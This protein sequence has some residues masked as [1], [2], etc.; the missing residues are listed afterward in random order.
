VGVPGIGKSRLVFELFEEVDRRPEL[1]TWRQGR[2]L[3]YGEGISYWALGEMVKAQAGILEGDDQ[4]AVARKVRS[5]VEEVVPP[6]DVAWVEGWL[7]PLVGLE[8]ELDIPRDRREES[9]TAWRRFLEGLAER[10]SLV[11]VFEDIHWADDGLLDFI[12][13]LVDWSADA[14]MLVLCTTRPELLDRRA[15]WGGGK[16][17]ALTLALSPLSD[18]EA[19]RL[20]D[21]V[22]ADAPVPAATRAALVERASGNPL[23]AQQFARLVFESG[24]V[25]DARLPETVHGL[26]AARLDALS[27]DEKALLQDAAVIGKVFWTGALGTSA[28]PAILQ[29]LQ[30]KEFIRRE[31]RA[32]VATDAEYAFCHVLVRDVAYSQIPRAERAAK[33][34]RAAQWIESLGRPQDHAELLAHHYAAA[35]ELAG[36]DEKAQLAERTRTAWR[37]AG[38]RSFALY[39]DPAAVQA[40]T[41][42][43]ELTPPDDPEHAQLRFRLARAEVRTAGAAAIEG[44]RSAAEALVAQGD[45]ATAAEAEALLVRQVWLTGDREAWMAHLDRATELAAQAPPSRSKAVVL[46]IRARYRFLGGDREGALIAGQEALELA[47]ELGIDEIR[48][49]ALNSLAIARHSMGESG[50]LDDLRESIRISEA[51]GYPVDASVGWNN[52]STLLEIDGQMPEAQQAIREASRVIRRSGSPS[53]VRWSE[54]TL[55]HLAFEEGDWDEALRRLDEHIAEIEAGAGHYHEGTLRFTRAEIRI[56]RDL[57][58][59][60]VGDMDRGL[61]ASRRAGDPQSVIPALAITTF[62]R[63]ARGELAEANAALD[64]LLATRRALRASFPFRG[65][66]RVVDATIALGRGEEFLSVAGAGRRTPWLDAAER[67]VAGDWA[68]A[69]EGYA[70]MGARLDEALARLRAAQQLAAGSRADEARHMVE[71][72]IA[73]YRRAGATRYLREADEVLAG[74]G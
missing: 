49:H 29:N 14:P 68:G 66:A 22:L 36:P 42:A 58:D 26:I 46:A 50:A 2:S 54:L 23:D 8:S 34:R 18:D 43:L 24:G 35:M 33:H 70:Q 51:A 53:D 40:Y 11:L 44:L 48:A 52:L 30:R 20:V 56:G 38:D 4:D 69:A 65:P 47:T 1:R 21:A 17:N 71:P 55:D 9:F 63:V 62:L 19:T 39:A 60:A 32:S 12:D 31:R 5:A 10:R 45:L 59:L 61:A 15:G 6:E 64:E 41:R 28:E 37:D 72:A 16:R 25:P 7:R 67:A 57:A 13:H 3:P 27:R 74:L 73:W